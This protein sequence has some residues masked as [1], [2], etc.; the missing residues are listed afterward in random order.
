MAKYCANISTILL[1]LAATLGARSSC[2]PSFV[3]Y[4]AVSWTY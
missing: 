1:N 2:Y 4:N 3:D